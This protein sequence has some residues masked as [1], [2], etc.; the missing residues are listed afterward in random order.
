MELVKSGPSAAKALVDERLED[1]HV[2][3]I[4]EDHPETGLF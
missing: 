2:D 4:S 3:H 1:I